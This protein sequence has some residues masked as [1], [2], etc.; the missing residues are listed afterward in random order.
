MSYAQ[1]H[2]ELLKNSP[3]AMALYQYYLSKR[4]KPADAFKRAVREA[5]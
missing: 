2:M 1:N 4:I 5:R 3:K